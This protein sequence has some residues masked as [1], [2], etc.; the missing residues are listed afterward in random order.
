MVPP[1]R[2]KMGENIAATTNIGNPVA[3]TD[4]ESDALTYSLSGA[5]AGLFSIGTSNGQIS[6]G[7]STALDFESPADSD[8]NNDY[9]LRVQVTDGKEAQG[10]ADASADDTIVET[11]S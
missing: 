3:A 6:I 10:S 1:F 9:D 4:P 11:M 5:D 2:S 7:A 8:D